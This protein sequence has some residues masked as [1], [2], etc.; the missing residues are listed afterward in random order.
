[1]PRRLICLIALLLPF[2]N[3]VNVLFLDVRAWGA[4][5]LGIWALAKPPAPGVRKNCRVL[6]LLLV[7]FAIAEL[8]IL[9]HSSAVPANVLS[10]A[11][12]D[13][14]YP[15]AVM[16]FWFAASRFLTTAEDVQTAVRWAAAGG[17]GTALYALYQLWQTGWVLSDRVGAAFINPNAL[18]AFIGVSALLL[19]QFSRFQTGRAKK[20]CLAVFLLLCV[21]LLITFSRAGQA[22]MVVGLAASWA[23]KTG[24]V[25]WRKVTLALIVAGTLAVT[26]GLY[27]KDLRV[28]WG[29]GGGSAA[30]ASASE[31]SQALEDWTRFQAGAYSLELWLDHPIMGVGLSIFPALNYAANGV[32]VGTHDTFLQILVGTGLVGLCCIVLVLCELWQR[33]P[34]GGRALL[35]PLALCY[36]TNT[37]FGDYVHHLEVNVLMGIAYVFASVQGKN[38][39]TVGAPS[40]LSGAP[41]D[42]AAL[43]G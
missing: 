43:P 29:S 33:L 32:Y 4:I 19:L 16:A 18:A 38:A 26:L 3:I 21:I 37:F 24:T 11:Q 28:R 14:K 23:T 41:G 7:F 25:S 36:L 2:P 9:L 34:V 20:L 40:N 35:L 30:E 39:A 5:V 22:A 6:T 17:F 12:V 1:M 15:A 13:F 27:V 8:E 10:E 31:V 42:V